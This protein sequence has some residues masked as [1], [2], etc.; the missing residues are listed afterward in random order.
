MSERR[1]RAALIRDAR[2][3]KEPATRIPGKRRNTVK[4]CRGVP[5]RAHEP[6][7]RGY[8]QHT[9][10]T[11]APEWRVLVCGSCGK[12]LDY[13]MPARLQS[14]RAVRPDWVTF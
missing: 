12:H 2:H 9:G 11:F 8:S 1:R 13:Y 5:G 3:T 7:C 10:T 4:W 6:V 14:L